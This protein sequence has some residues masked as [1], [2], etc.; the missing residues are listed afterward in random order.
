VLTYQHINVNPQKKKKQKEKI[1]TTTWLFFSLCKPKGLRPHADPAAS[2]RLANVRTLGRD[3]MK[4]QPFVEAAPILGTTLIL[5]Q[6][7]ACPERSVGA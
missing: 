2:L 6:A 1:T 3:L 4:Q 5:Q 7:G